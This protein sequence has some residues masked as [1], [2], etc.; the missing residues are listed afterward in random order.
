MRIPFTNLE[1]NVVSSAG[2]TGLVLQKSA[3]IFS[4]PIG[5]GVRIRRDD[6]YNVYRSSGD[7]FACVREWRENLGIGGLRYV[8]PND[9]ERPVNAAAVK[10]VEAVLQWFRG[11]NNL[12]GRVVRDLGV[13]GNAYLEKVYNKARTEIVG[14]APMDPR[15]VTPKMDE[16]GNVTGYSQSNG[17][18][19]VIF[20]A[21]D[22]IHFKLEDD[23]DNEAVGFSPLEPVLIET[24]TDLAAST[25]NMSFFNNNAQPA[26]H[27]VLDDNVGDEAAKEFLDEIK[28]KFSGASNQHKP[29]A[30]RGIKEIKTVAFS[31]RDMEYLQGRRFSTEKICAAY[32]VPKFMLGY[33]ETVNNNNGTELQR[34]FWESTIQPLEEKFM[35]TLNA[36][37]LA[38][39]GLS[40]V[41]RIEFA[42][43]PSLEQAEIE[44]RAL[45]E[46]RNGVITL[47]EYRTKTR[48]KLDK[49]QENM[50]NVDA[51]IIRDGGATKLLEDVGTDV[52]DPTGADAQVNR[53]LNTLEQEY[54][55]VR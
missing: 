27:Y 8:D 20:E 38:H 17:Q 45:E 47:R 21:Q 51:F 36:G 7:V 13:A 50:V 6:L 42:P 12:K 22:V 25:T 33:T 14:L 35:A 29:I 55:S 4:N 16:S 54:A 9:P 15:T 10:K 34:K 26:T 44:K 5:L 19:T 3:S 30:L 11:F 18:K 48:Q 43:L 40:D 52:S 41:L 1:L 46:L 23:P 32:G 49:D 53:I 2:R 37:L 39:M 31:Q 24:K 28:E